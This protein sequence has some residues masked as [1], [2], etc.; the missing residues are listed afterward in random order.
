MG[1]GLFAIIVVDR[2]EIICYN[3][4]WFELAVSLE[5]RRW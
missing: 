5:I 2:C 4:N 3:T 1:N